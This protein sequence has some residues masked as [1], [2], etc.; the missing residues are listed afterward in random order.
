MIKR[1]VFDPP[2][3]LARSPTSTR[4]VRVT[5]AQVLPELT[6][7]PQHRSVGIEWFRDIGH[8]RRYDREHRSDDST[9][10]VIA[11]EHVLRGEDWLERRWRDGGPRY[12][13]MAMALRAEGLTPAGFSE[14]WRSRAGKVGA[15]PIPD[16]AKGLAYVQNH[17]VAGEKST[18]DAVNEVYFDDV[19]SMRVRMTWLDEA[20]KTRGEDDLVRANWFLALREDLLGEQRGPHSRE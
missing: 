3:G 15:T 8:L 4:P 20:M 11:E 13:Q 10:L 19:D 5:I 18:Y 16:G 1:I 2:E 9:P 17:P 12:K 6:P 14:L 7:E